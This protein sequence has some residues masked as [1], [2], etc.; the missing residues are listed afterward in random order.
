MPKGHSALLAMKYSVDFLDAGE[1]SCRMG[2][3]T[4]LETSL[5]LI[6][7]GDRKQTIQA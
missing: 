3:E 5:I 7:I 2:G 4:S 1:I 6:S